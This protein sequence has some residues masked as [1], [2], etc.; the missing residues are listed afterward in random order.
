MLYK[1]KD[2]SGQ[3]VYSDQPPSASDAS[4]PVVVIRNGVVV[5][6]I[7]AKRDDPYAKAKGYI[8]DAKKHIPKALVYVEYI[9]YLRKNNPALSLIH[10]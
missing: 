6:T 8:S 2:G 7:S 4:S 5:D 3:A 1:Y 10:I 9:E